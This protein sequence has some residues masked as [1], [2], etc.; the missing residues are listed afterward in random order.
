MA[1]S[2]SPC[3]KYSAAAIWD[4]GLAPLGEAESGSE[5]SRILCDVKD[6]A[7]VAFLRWA[8]PQ[9]RLRWTGFRKVRRQVCRR[10]NRRC[11]ELALADL[12][13]YRAHLATHSEEWNHLDAL[14]RI[15]ISRFYRDRGVFDQL[16]GSILPVLAEHARAR[17]PSELWCW[18]A[19]CASG[20]EPYTLSLLWAFQLRARFPDIR[21]RVIAT[22]ADRQL[23]DRARAARYRA[24]SLKELPEEWVKQAFTREGDLYRLHDELR[25]PVEL[26]CEDIRTHFPKERFD[27]ILCRNLVCT[28]FEEALQRE[29][30][31]NLVERLVPGGLLVIGAHESLP[32]L[33]PGLSPREEKLGLYQRSGGQRDRTHPISSKSTKT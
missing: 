2:F 19:G 32:Y 29:V 25:A 1:G 17:C 7:C 5:R 13:E 31:A 12:D 20:E 24:S 26:R 9:L 3:K 30:L 4:P 6:P 14:C 15:P 23:L 33:P 11:R 8:L 21:L 16:A 18:S 28:Y 10:I 27:L 22:D